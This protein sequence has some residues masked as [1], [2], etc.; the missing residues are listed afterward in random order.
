MSALTPANLF[1]TFLRKE[2]DLLD[3]LVKSTL[4]FDYAVKRQKKGTWARAPVWHITTWD[5]FFLTCQIRRPSPTCGETQTIFNL[6]FLLY[7][8]AAVRV[9]ARSLAAAKRLSS[10]LSSPSVLYTALSS[11]TKVA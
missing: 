2:V 10:P 8:F 6:P 4:A 7:R 5:F 3:N 11:K 1:N 9:E